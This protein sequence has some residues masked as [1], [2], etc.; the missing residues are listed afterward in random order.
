MPL[1]LTLQTSALALGL[2]FLLFPLSAS[3]ASLASRIGFPEA[4]W[5]RLMQ[6]ESLAARPTL[7]RQLVYWQGDHEAIGTQMARHLEAS[8]SLIYRDLLF[9]WVKGARTREEVL[10]QMPHEISLEEAQTF[11]E[12]LQK[13]MPTIWNEVQGFARQLGV[14]PL[15]LLQLLGSISP[16]GGCSAIALGP[17]RT[18]N[19]QV[20]IGFSYDFHPALDEKLMVLRKPLKGYATLGNSLL[21]FGLYDGINEKGL[22]VGSNLVVDPQKAPG[23]FFGF[24]VRRVLEE[25]ATTA[26]AIQL[27]QSLLIRDSYSFLIADR[28]GDMVVVEANRGK[29]ALRRPAQAGAIWSSNVF[30]TPEMANANRYLMPNAVHRSERTQVYL[31]QRDRWAEAELSAWMRQDFTEGGIALKYYEPFIL[32]NLYHYTADLQSLKLTYYPAGGNQGQLV[33]FGRMI[34]TPPQR[35]SQ[36]VVARFVSP[37]ANQAAD[38]H[39]FADLDWW[40]S[41]QNQGWQLQTQFGGSLQPL[42]AAAETRLAYRI[43]LGNSVWGPY[44]DVGLRQNL[45]PVFHRWGPY[46]RWASKTWV[47]LEYGREQVQYFTALEEIKQGNGYQTA[48]PEQRLLDQETTSFTTQVQ[49]VAVQLHHSLGPMALVDHAEQTKWG[50][51][52]QPAAFYNFETGLSQSFGRELSNNFMVMVPL[53]APDWALGIFHQQHQNLDETGWASFMGLQLH[54]LNAPAGANLM[55]VWKQQ[56]F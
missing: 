4:T 54:F 19:G 11:G 30:L 42:G 35:D 21:L 55:L 22:F 18:Q 28:Q 2:L 48:S 7:E 25:A 33:D 31:T 51:P 37:L 34:E 50:Q 20:L 39:E 16:E 23:L 38:L 15:Q 8:S 5:N 27:L 41:P 56:W 12:H 6:E 40:S 9:S 43:P 1:K 10:A 14:P 32:G 47:D 44:L 29:I 26:E 17:G 45:S 3:A 46:L 13:A 24:V 53:G 36:G 52:P 49:R